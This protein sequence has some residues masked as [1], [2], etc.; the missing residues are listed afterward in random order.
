MYR[1]EY[2]RPEFK[3]KEWKSLNGQWDFHIEGTAYDKIEVPFVFQSQMSGIH[4]NGMYNYVEYRRSFEVPESWEGKRIFVCFGAVDYSCDVCING[5]HIGSHEGGN[6]SFTMDMT[7][8]LVKGLNEILVKVF[9]PCDDETIPRGKQYWKEKKESI[10]YTRSTGIWQSV[11]IEPKEKVNI[12]YIHF[13]PDIDKGS[14][15][16]DLE[17]EGWYE[18]DSVL[19]KLD[20]EIYFKG[21]KVYSGSTDIYDRHVRFSVDLFHRMI[22]RTMNHDGGWCWSP[23]KPNLFDVVVRLK[24]GEDCLD[25]VETYFGMRKIEAKDGMVYLNNRPYYQK[26]ILDQ[27]YWPESLMTAPSQEDYVT[28]IRMAKEMG[29]NGCRKHQKAE[30][31]LFLYHADKM[32]FLVWSEIGACA[33]YSMESSQRTIKEWGE[34]VRR[35]YNHPCIVTWVVLNESW[36]VPNIRF[37]KKQQAHSLALYYNMKSMDQTRLVVSN[38][39]WEMTATDICAVHNYEHGGKEE[40]EKQRIFESTL[41]DGES[42]VNSLPTGRKI[43]ADGYEFRG[44]P[45]L[46]TEFGGLSYAKDC[47]KGWGYT[48][49]DSDEEFIE[50]YRRLISAIQK[51]SVLYGY[52]YTQLSDVE[53]EVNGLLTADR[54]YKV[55]PEKIRKINEI[56]CKYKVK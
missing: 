35:D 25:E 15:D 29:F 16:V 26:L 55:D 1:T 2:P 51:S 49:I 28:D 53:Q 48:T 22:M 10:W 7:D 20:T 47:D 17:M 30:D 13:T 24:N 4:D 27:G 36:G 8:A 52:C 50:T 5:K 12:E 19:L 21:E 37:D 23:E 18:K 45:V 46:L 31:P 39:G 32:G 54:K 14:V 33:S 34:I 42:I 40:L 41:Q 9:D 44:E 11:F 6:T 38:D 3:R 56:I 43:Y